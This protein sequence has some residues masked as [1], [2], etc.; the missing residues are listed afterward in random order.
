[1]LLTAMFV[2]FG[3][4]V[5]AP[6]IFIDPHTHLNWAENAINFALIGSAWA[7]AVPVPVVKSK[8]IG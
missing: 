1:M 8:E 6:T 4:L 2:V 3:I 5:H 7:I